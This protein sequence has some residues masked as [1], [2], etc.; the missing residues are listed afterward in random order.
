MTTT[1]TKPWE[2]RKAYGGIWFHRVETPERRIF[3]AYD[4]N[5]NAACEPAFGLV[6]SCE[7]PNE[8]STLCPECIEVCKAEPAG[9]PPR[10]A[11]SAPLG[12]TRDG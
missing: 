12:E 11:S 8:G 9:R 1:Q 3:H 10:T 7:E 2:W 6:Q 5:D 4:V